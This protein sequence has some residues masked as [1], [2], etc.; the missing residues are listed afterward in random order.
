MA[1]DTSVIV[2]Q[3]IIDNGNVEA[4]IVLLKSNHYTCLLHEY[5]FPSLYA[6]NQKYIAVFRI[7]TAGQ[8]LSFVSWRGFF[9]HY[10]VIFLLILLFLLSLFSWRLRVCL[11]LKPGSRLCWVFFTINLLLLRLE[12]RMRPTWTP[13]D[14][15]HWWNSHL[16]T[17]T[18]ASPHIYVELS[19]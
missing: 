13:Y 6:G 19:S 14:G 8:I 7:H 11:R 2:E 1:K 18:C 12:N 5:M 17:L 16:R 3:V 9:Y 4:I 15:Q 10:W